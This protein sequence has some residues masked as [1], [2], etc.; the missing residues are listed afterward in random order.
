M[1]PAHKGMQLKQDLDRMSEANRELRERVT[2]LERELELM[3]AAASPE[4]R[5]AEAETVET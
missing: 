5:E 3:R 2:K 4:K 1:T